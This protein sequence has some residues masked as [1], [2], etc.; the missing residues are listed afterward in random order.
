MLGCFFLPVNR[1][2]TREFPNV[3]LLSSILHLWVAQE[4]GIDILIISLYVDDLLYMGSSSKMNDKFKAAMMNEF[5]MKDLGIMK[6]FLG[7]EV[8]QRRMRF[9]FL[10]QS[11]HR[12]C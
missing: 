7:M 2:K 12:I 6:Y 11:M 10:R 4:E 3:D 1:G 8:Y 9:S 5:E